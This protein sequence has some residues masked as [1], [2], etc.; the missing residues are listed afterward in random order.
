MCLVS[1]GDWWDGGREGVEARGLTVVVVVALWAVL[2]VVVDVVGVEEVLVEDFDREI[3]SDREGGYVLAVDALKMMEDDETDDWVNDSCTK[4]VAVD[5]TVS[6]EADDG[7]DSEETEEEVP[8][9]E[10]VDVLVV[11]RMTVGMQGEAIPPAKKTKRSV[12]RANMVT[13]FERK[14]WKYC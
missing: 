5:T 7:M 6:V 1:G 4:V 14:E 12:R 8:G 2:E 11:L 10:M 13:V 3:L 9:L